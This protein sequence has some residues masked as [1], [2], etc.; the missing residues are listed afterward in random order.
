MILLLAGG[1]IQVWAQAPT[2]IEDFFLPG[3]Q[4]QESGNLETPSKCDNCHGGYDPAVEPAYTWR[5]SMMSQAAR[6][7][8]YFASVAIANQD[9]GESGDL[10]IR[11]HSPAGW[12]EGRSVPTDGSALNNN[13]REGVQCD[14][15]HKLVRPTQ[16]G[17]NPYQGD[18]DYTAGTYASDQGYLATLSVIP[19][20]PANGMYI[21][22]SDNAK[23][24]PFVDAV[25]THQ[26]FY[27]PFHREAAT[28]GTCHDV[29]NPAFSKDPNGKYVLNDLDTP[30][31]N[32][33]PYSMFP[34]ERTYS[35]WLMSDYSSAEGVYAP[36]FGGNIDTVS[37]CQDCH[38][39]DVTGKGCN[40][41]GAPVRDNLPMHDMTGGNTFVPLLIESVYPGQSDQAA[42]A[43]GVQRA[44]SMLQRAA[45]MN[46]EAPESGG[47]YSA[48]VTLT[49]ETGHKLPSGY[50]EGRRMWINVR[51]YDS[52]SNLIYESGAYDT[53]TG[54]LDHDPDVKIYEIKPGLTDGIAEALG[55]GYTAGPSFHFAVNDTVYFDNRIPPRGFTNTNF[56]M[57]QSP[58]IG[59]SYADGQYWDETEYEIPLLTAT[60]IATLYYQT[61]SKE[62]AEFLQAENVTNE[63]GDIFFNLWANNG[64]SRPVVMV[65]DTLEIVPIQ[66]NHAPILDEIGPQEVAEG[67]SLNFAV[68]A[69]DPDGAAPS[70]IAENLPANAAFIDHDNGTG[71]FDFNPDYTQAGSYD[72]RFI[73]SDGSLADT[74]LVIID[75]I[76]TNQAPLLDPVGDKSGT[77]GVI[78]SF[79][80]TASDVDGD[81]VTLYSENMPGG[82]TFLYDGWSTELEK[83]TGIFSWTPGNTDIGVHSGIRFVA[84]DGSLIVDELISI[85]ITG[86]TYLCGDAN[87]SGG[88]DI[89]DIVYLVSY[90]FTGGPEPSPYESADVNCSGM[91]DIDD[92]VWLI[93]YIF[94]GG[95][96]PCDTDDDGELD[97]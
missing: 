12:L 40:K 25:A 96:D 11:C 74:E 70:L 39:Q 43:D 36:Q 91:T 61:T 89:D 92:I 24:G 23:R 37:T 52:L 83:Y 88:V 6:D 66:D 65:A 46:L 57:I 47:E 44:T 10:C 2:T 87:A 19:T 14:F 95:S 56:E 86:A 81:S 26:M 8:L 82:A 67:S 3:S 32:F 93:D 75:V 79:I 33:D 35:E 60:L 30:A 85:T 1:A 51:A 58:P 9:A 7:P 69:S 34:V 22:D 59:Y 78:L 54:I 53:A 28:C 21:A 77:S 48:T 16:L 27:S 13:D 68:T 55:D 4:P 84:T 73:A 5:G 50:P 15:C 29:S 18:A 76:E 42:L 64:K 63:W 41:S 80:V 72:V 49:N 90:I 38:M 31:P 71:T 17:V 97:C 20:H 45:S 62:Y 94:T